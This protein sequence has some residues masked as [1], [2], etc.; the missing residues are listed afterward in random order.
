MNAAFQ[1]IHDTTVRLLKAEAKA[2]GLSPHIIHR[3]C[4]R[5]TEARDARCRVAAAL[6]DEFPLW[7]VARALDTTVDNVRRLVKREPTTKKM[8]QGDEVRLRR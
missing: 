4:S 8:S 2:T 3:H 5:N 7:M 1:Q 6:A